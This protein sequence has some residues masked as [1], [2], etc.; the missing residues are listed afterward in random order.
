MKLTSTDVFSPGYYV[1]TFNS[2]S[3]A[4]LKDPVY[5]V[6]TN[7][8]TGERVSLDGMDPDG[9]WAAVDITDARSLETASDERVAYIRT[10]TTD[11]ATAT[12]LQ[13][14]MDVKRI[15]EAAAAAGVISMQNQPAERKTVR[16]PD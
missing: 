15:I 16:R 9:G 13:V 7:M 14:S 2:N 1:I 8:L 11:R 4:V 5:D 3:I 10:I 6:A 12:R